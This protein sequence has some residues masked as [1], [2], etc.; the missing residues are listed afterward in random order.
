MDRSKREPPKAA[1]RKTR[2]AGKSDL[3]DAARAA[4]AAR[5]D[6]GSWFATQAGRLPKDFALEIQAVY[7]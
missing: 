6:F 2:T 7:S 3:D 4:A 1:P 5:D